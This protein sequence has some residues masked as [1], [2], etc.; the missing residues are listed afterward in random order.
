MEAGTLSPADGQA[1]AWHYT[2]A[3]VPDVQAATTA[4]AWQRR[5][6]RAV[7]ALKTSLRPTAA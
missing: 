2:T 6:S 5:R 7:H 1:I 3:P 4:G